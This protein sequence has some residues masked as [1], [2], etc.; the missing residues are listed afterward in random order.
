MRVGIGAI[1]R[2]RPV[3]F[4][5]LLESLAAM[6]RPEGVELIFL[7]AENDTAPLAGDVVEAFRAGVA[8]PVRLELE[9]RPGIPM[10][11]NRVLDM[12]LEEGVDY[13]TFVD[14]D[15]VVAPDWL[16]VLLEGVRA[17]G[18]E[19]AGGPVRIVAPSG[20][21]TPWNRAVLQ[22]LQASAEKRTRLRSKLARE[23]RDDEIAVYTNNWCLSLAAQRRTG[24][25]F[26]ERLQFTGGSDTRF[27]LDFAAAGGRVGFVPDAVVDDVIPQKRL[28][29][30]YHYRR[31]R[32]QSTN[33]VMLRGKSAFKCFQQALL[34]CLDGMLTLLTVPVSG[35]YGVV[36]AVHKF[37]VAAGRI[38]G[39][40]GRRSSHYAAGSEGVH[41]E[42]RS[43][44]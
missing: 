44:G 1:T 5:T 8:E 34:R 7:F 41:T 14:D 15:E 37:G 4:A 30:G 29:P 19:L 27:S 13:L 24:A 17:R 32:D 16:M 25:R 10:A 18:L 2:R 22:Y 21:L 43:G 23:D 31:A 12:A 40:L 26:D 33:A 35:R 20:V 36:K 11:R 38:R 9:Q 3:T 6:Q 42:Q 39:A 28:T